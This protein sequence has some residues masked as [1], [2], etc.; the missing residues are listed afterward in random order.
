MGGGR[1]NIFHCYELFGLPYESVFVYFCCREKFNGDK[2]GVEGLLVFDCVGVESVTQ[3]ARGFGCRQELENGSVGCD[4][5]LKTK[6]TTHQS[7]SPAFL[8][9]LAPVS[10]CAP[11]RGINMSVRCPPSRCERWRFSAAAA[12][13]LAAL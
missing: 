6:W 5:G 12:S 10:H 4:T 11:S 2:K 3:C 7:G 1:A 8:G 13:P 9:A